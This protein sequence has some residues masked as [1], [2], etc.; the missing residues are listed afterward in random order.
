MIGILSK[1]KDEIDISDIQDLIDS[2]VPEGEQIEFKRELQARG[3]GS[4]DPWM[5]DQSLIGDRAKNHILEE[6]VAFANAHG[7]VLLLGI[8]ESDTNPPVAADISPVPQCAELA[9]RLKLIFR[10]RVEPQLPVLDV[11]AVSTEGENGVVIIRVGRSRNAPHRVTNTLVCPIRRADRCEEMSMREIQDMTLNVSRGLERLDKRLL[12]R[13]ERF[14]DEFKHLE[15]PEDAIGIRMTAA[16]VGDEIWFDRVFGQ[17][18][19]I[20]EL[21]VPWSMVSRQS[22]NG[23]QNLETPTYFPPQ[24]WRPILRGAR[25]EIGDIS[26]AEIP[27]LQIAYRELYCDGLIEMGFLSVGSSFR[28]WPFPP[29]WPIV[30]FANVAIW[31]DYVRKQADI[32]TAEYVLEVEIR[33]LGNTAFYVGRDGSRSRAMF[34]GVRHLENLLPK[35]FDLKF[36]RYPLGDSDEFTKLLAWFHRDFWHSLRK[37]DGPEDPGFKIEGWR[38]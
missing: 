11:F 32:P 33:T 24:Y 1:P 12:E 9:E 38:T 18:R 27:H 26:S 8:K 34:S 10:D 19:I 14:Q 2:E 35:L 30:I 15:T 25:A 29:D 17:G 21:E 4:P 28:E 37:D 23:T 20:H 16:P 36:P 7:G 22:G 31:A 13:S 5:S 6:A 3:N